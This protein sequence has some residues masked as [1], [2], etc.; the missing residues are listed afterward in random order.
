MLQGETGNN[1]DKSKKN[2]E[3]KEIDLQNLT[4]RSNIGVDESLF[5]FSLFI[6]P[7]NSSSFLYASLYSCFPLNLSQ[8]I[9]FLSFKSIP[10][11]IL[12]FL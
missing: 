1:V 6:F 8:F 10:V 11:Y 7:L 4:W 2:C 12:S 9:F 3:F 5:H